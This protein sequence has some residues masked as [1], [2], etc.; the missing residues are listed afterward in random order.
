MIHITIGVKTDMEK[1][2]SLS[3][4]GIILRFIHDSQEIEKSIGVFFGYCTNYNAYARAML[5]AI[6]S[7]K[8]EI[9]MKEPIKFLFDKKTHISNILSSK[10]EDEVI[11]ELR[12]H[13]LGVD[14]ELVG[15]TDEVDSKLLVRAAT[16]A[17]TCLANKDSI[18]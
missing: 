16:L 3:S 12:K 7:I 5:V 2:Q 13:L 14:M 18:V 6:V 9:K 17:N 8:H 1:A 15:K 11:S 10:K 4:A